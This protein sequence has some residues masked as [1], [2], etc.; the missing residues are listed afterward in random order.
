MYDPMDDVRSG[1]AFGDTRHNIVGKL[2]AESF[3]DIDFTLF[4][5]LIG[6]FGL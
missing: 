4:A 2:A 6:G 5:K 3:V 1:N